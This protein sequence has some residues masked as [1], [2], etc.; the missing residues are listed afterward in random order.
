MGSLLNLIAV[1][2]PP[3]RNSALECI[4]C[5]SQNWTKHLREKLK[6]KVVSS[7]N[8][9]SASEWR[10]RPRNPTLHVTGPMYLIISPKCLTFAWYRIYYHCLFYY[11]SP[12][13][14]KESCFTALAQF[15]YLDYNCDPSLSKW[16]S[17]CQLTNIDSCLCAQHQAQ[18]WQWRERC[19][20]QTWSALVTLTDRIIWA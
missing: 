13:K 2:F 3:I 11:Y 12:P 17:G 16:K 4:I 7:L 9:T 15:L 19:T 1:P 14:P 20:T 18:R 10:T 5:L 8:V 6:P